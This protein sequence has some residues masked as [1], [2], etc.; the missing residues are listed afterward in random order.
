MLPPLQR[1]ILLG[2]SIQLKEL[3]RPLHEFKVI[4]VLRSAQLLHL[5]ML[6]HLTLIKRL[7]QELKVIDK[8]MRVFRHEVDTTQIDTAWE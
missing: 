5:D 1:I 2:P 3:L 4:L 8:L 6:L 7:L